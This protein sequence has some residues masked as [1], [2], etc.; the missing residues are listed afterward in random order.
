MLPR[1]R[2]DL[3]RC[4]E[5]RDGPERCE[6]RHRP[7][8]RARVRRKAV[9]RVELFD[10]AALERRRVAADVED[11]AEE[12]G[13]EVDEDREDDEELDELPRGEVHRDAPR[14]EDLN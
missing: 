2:V 5:G 1:A 4:G 13:D 6:R 9:G 12:A 8:E 3:V 14:G 11:D 10:P 7:P